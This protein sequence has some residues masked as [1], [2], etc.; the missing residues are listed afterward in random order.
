MFTPSNTRFR[1]CVDRFHRQVAIY[2]FHMHTYTVLNVRLCY[3]GL[4]F[5]T[6]LR[7]RRVSGQGGIQNNK[8]VAF[9]EAGMGQ[10]NAC[11]SAR[12]QT[13]SHY[14]FPRPFP[15]LRNSAA[16]TNPCLGSAH[17][18]ENPFQVPGSFGAPIQRLT[19]TEPP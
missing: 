12:V 15:W 1:V 4:P 6:D 5:N 11:N 19:Q 18:V 9:T 10:A 16:H 8:W 13:K 3:E 7:V 2:Q 14:T 17:C